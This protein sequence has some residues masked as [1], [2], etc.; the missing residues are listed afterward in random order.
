MQSISIV[1]PTYNSAQILPACLESI[2]EQDYPKD[3]VEIIIADAGSSDG[4]VEIARQFTNKVYS[5]PLKTGE[6]GKAVGVNH[7]TGEIIALID[8]DN[9]LPAKDWLTRMVAPFA[10]P[11][12]AGTEPLYY[13]HREEDGIITRYCALM[14]MNDPLCLFMGNYD[15]MN[16]IT[17]KWTEM[18]VDE[19]ELGDYLKVGL[20]EKKLPT[21]GA[22]GFLVRKKLLDTCS[23]KD[24]LFDIDVVYELVTQGHSKFAKVKTGII[25]IFS[26]SISTFIKKQRRRIKDYGY[27]EKMGVRKYPWSALSKEKLLKFI[28]Y[29]I[30]VF[31]LVVQV[32]QGWMQKRD[33]AWAFHLVACWVTLFVYGWGTVRNIVCAEEEDRSTWGQ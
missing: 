13:T 20:D 21:I 14:G 19:E 11:E 30:V 1:I 8:S 23:I 31:P 15:R 25:H 22:N 29:T 3:K 2:R 7:A 12:I 10:D 4:T 5:N 6:A 32:M 24:Y 16:L 27:Y 33:V 28:V 17:G 26:G 9:I 18:P